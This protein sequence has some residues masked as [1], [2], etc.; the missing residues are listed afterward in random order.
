MGNKKVSDYDIE[1]L[2]DTNSVNQIAI[3]H[4]HRYKFASNFIKNKI[5]LDIA[6]GEGYG[7]NLLSKNAS[8]VIAVDIDKETL[9]HAKNKYSTS[10]IDFKHGSVTNIPLLSKSIDVIVS[11]ETLEHILEHE[12]MIDE[13]KRVIKDDG[14]IIISSPN[15]LNYT[16]KVNHVN[17]H[18]LKELYESEFIDLMKNN[19]E[20]FDIYYQ[21]Y[22]NNSVI[23]PKDSSVII[24]NGDFNQINNYTI[25]ENAK[26]LIALIGIAAKI[27]YQKD[28]VFFNQDFN[29]STVK[30]EGMNSI[31]KSWS[32][33]LGNLL[34]KPFSFMKRLVK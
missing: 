2:G 27:P 25:S 30:I 10:N 1:R 34:L 12:K 19:F 20:F 3:E 15:K 31:K 9:E 21:D 5:V 18:H 4:L 13:F 7:S 33:Q 23:A 29:H 24:Y 8:K 26:Y 32:Y 17:T 28:S 11:F 16:D 14:I 22:I 6:C